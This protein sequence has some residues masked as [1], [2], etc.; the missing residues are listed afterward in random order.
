MFMRLILTCICLFLFN[1]FIFS[2]CQIPCGIYGDANQFED[3]FQHVQTIEKSMIKLTEDTLNSNQSV[4]WVMNKE[5]HA[6]NIQDVMN[7]Y[8]L[9][10]RVKPV[11][12][13]NKQAYKRYSTLL[14]YAH[15]VIVLA[16]KAKQNTDVKVAISLKE[17]LVRFQDY[18]NNK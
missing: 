9:S 18:Y 7:H 3:L 8:F 17:S 11:Q 12:S 1:S 15:E 6:S 13:S 16:M 2:H 10:Q 14:V 4:R 5:E